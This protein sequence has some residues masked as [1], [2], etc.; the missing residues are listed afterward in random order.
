MHSESIH[1]L[2]EEEY[3]LLLHELEAAQ[4]ANDRLRD[5]LK[6][7]LKA[8]EQA[9]RSAA[10]ARRAHS[11][12]V[13]TLTETMRENTALTIERD[14]WRVRAQRNHPAADPPPPPPG[15][16]GYDL[17]TLVGIDRVSEDE[18]KAIRKAMARLHHPDSGGDAERMKQWNAALDR[19]EHSIG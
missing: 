6:K 13:E 19:V 12:M 8:T 15:Y 16:A 17:R 9:E 14:M 4:T 1:H 5:Q 18:V 3:L 11:K 10:E 7:A 2:T